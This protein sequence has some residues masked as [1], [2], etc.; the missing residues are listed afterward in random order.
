MSAFKNFLVAV[1]KKRTNNENEVRNKRHLL[2]SLNREVVLTI[3]CKYAL[4]GQINYTGVLERE[5]LLVEDG[6]RIENVDTEQIFVFNASN[7]YQII[8]HT[9]TV[10]IILI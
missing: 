1:G 4:F 2:L 8:T 5:M 10:N 6:F 3:R 7:V 9:N